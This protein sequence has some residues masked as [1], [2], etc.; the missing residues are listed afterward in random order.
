MF[1]DNEKFKRKEEMG[2]GHGAAP[3]HFLHLLAQSDL[4]TGLGLVGT[5]GRAASGRE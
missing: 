2:A 5:R 1:N 3:R 4:E